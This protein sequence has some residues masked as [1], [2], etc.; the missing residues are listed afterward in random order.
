M[1]YE[2]SVGGLLALLRR[3]I[4]MLIFIPLVAAIIAYALPTY[5]AKPLYQSTAKVYLDR[6]ASSE[7]ALV[8]KISLYVNVATGEAAAT[9]A[10]GVM[11]REL[12]VKEFQSMINIATEDDVL[13]ITGRSAE[14][15]LAMEA[16]EALVQVMPE[17]FPQSLN[18]TA[19]AIIEEASLPGSPVN[20]VS[21]RN[22]V[23]AGLFGI[24]LATGLALF[25][26]YFHGRVH[27]ASQLKQLGVGLLASIPKL[28]LAPDAII[29]VEKP[30]SSAAESY[31]KL[32][33]Q[34]RAAGQGVKS[35][36]VAGSQEER[37]ATVALN[38]ASALAISGSKVLLV[39]GDLRRPSFPE[40][41]PGRKDSLTDLV[42]GSE[43]EGFEAGPVENLWLL[44]GGRPE[45]PLAV[46]C[47][48]Q[49]YKLLKE[50]EE[51]FDWV[52]IAAPAL[53]P[54]SEAIIWSTITGGMLY[55]IKGDFTSINGV[56]RALE[57]LKAANA[58]VVGAV[59]T[60]VK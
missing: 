51:D 3:R 47:S 25:I 56:H 11:A 41:F 22:V 44:P 40:S 27:S 19:V 1:N 60:N 35:L 29:T 34:L 26:E 7:L 42:G 16:V 17:I 14:P 12:T 10:V 6:S 9:K 36:T 20:R 33:A 46:I 23:V 21:K 43:R 50:F 30:D 5:L 53:A 28:G 15:A 58:N 31:F 4:A 2:L 52:I 45:N 37:P 8:P 18:V 24:V 49:V 59:L 39:D 13:I 38:L 54:G 32:V 55:N 48:Q 57:Q